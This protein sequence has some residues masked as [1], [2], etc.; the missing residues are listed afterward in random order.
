VD[1]ASEAATA[2]APKSTEVK[3]ITGW[4]R[5]LVLPLAL[6]MRLWLRT[7]RVDI[8]PEHARIIKESPSPVAFVLWHNRLFFV[9]EVARRWRSHRKVY[10]LVSASK[11]G[12][13]L[14]AFFEAVGIRAVRGSSSRL[15]REAA[16][17]LIDTLRDGND[18]GITPDGPR[19]P[20]YDFKG[21]ALIVTRRAHAGMI[22]LGM[23]FH[24]SW[25]LRSWDRFAIP[26]PFSKVSLTA[27]W[28][29]PEELEGDREVIASGLRQRMI[30]S[31][32]DR[33]P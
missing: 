24:A 22:L 2:P 17:A 9:A 27:E 7:L 28:V 26:K 3:H 19:G 31:N 30:A 15:G 4:K 13:W 23:D 18:T 11:D 21:G 10:G 12:A 25:R 29:K 8:S 20:C 32:P 5:L 33:T 14:E 16:T 6:M 1:Q